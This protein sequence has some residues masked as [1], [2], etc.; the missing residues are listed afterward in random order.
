MDRYEEELTEFNTELDDELFSTYFDNYARFIEQ[1]EQFIKR[2]GTA[3][4]KAVGD[5]NVIHIMALDMIIAEELTPT[6]NEDTFRVVVAG[7][8]HL[9]NNLKK[10]VKIPR[11]RK[12]K[13][14]TTFI[15][16]T[17]LL[18]ETVLDTYCDYALGEVSEE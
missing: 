17:L 10:L 14:I 4:Y 6:D 1:R 3:I 18:S 2:Y 12:N 11:G 15:T 5:L 13:N 16:N 7:I 8:F 9:Y